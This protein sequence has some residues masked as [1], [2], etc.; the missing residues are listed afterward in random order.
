MTSRRG[1]YVYLE[2][3][4]RDTSRRNTNAAKLFL[5]HSSSM[6]ALLTLRY[7]F[8]GQPHV[9]LQKEGY[10]RGTGE[11]EMISCDVSPRTDQRPLENFN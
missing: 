1:V 9:C 5:N 2:G 6:T 4:R 7:V 11:P 3:E 8:T 10:M